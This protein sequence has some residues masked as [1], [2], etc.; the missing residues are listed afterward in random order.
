MTNC[1][2][3]QRYNV[4]VAQF[5]NYVKTMCEKKGLQRG[6]DQNDFESPH[7][8]YHSSYRVVGDKKMCYSE[9]YQTMTEFKRKIGSNGYFT[10]DF[11]EVEVT[12]LVIENQKWPADDAPCKA[13]TCRQFPYDLQTYI[14]NFDGSCY[15]EICEFH[16]YDDKRGYGY[17]YQANEDAKEQA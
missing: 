1:I 4:T 11:E 7:H 2:E 15:N 14:L 8:Q 10:N 16:F 13:E 6:F 12:K 3:I 9:G 17:Y 5:L